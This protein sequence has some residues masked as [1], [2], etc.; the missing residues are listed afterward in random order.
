MA[1]PKKTGLDYYYKDV[2]QMD[3]FRVMDLMEKYGT[4]GYV[5]LDMAMSCVY[6][7]GYYLEMPIKR[8]ASYIYRYVAGSC[9]QNSSDIA[10]MIIYCGE[11]GIFDKELLSQSVITSREIQEHYSNVSAR[12]KADKS[13]YWLLPENTDKPSEEK[14]A[15]AETGINATETGINAAETGIIATETGINATETGINA[16]IIPQSKANK[17]KAN[18]TKQNQIKANQSKSKQSKHTSA[19]EIFCDPDDTGPAD[20]PADGFAWDAAAGNIGEE[21]AA[22]DDAFAD[23]A[24]GEKEEKDDDDGYS[25]IEEAY[26]AAVGRN[27]NDT[28]RADIDTI[29]REG[30]DDRL[31]IYAVKRVASRRPPVKINSFRYFL[32]K[33]RDMLSERDET[34]Y[35]APRPSYRRDDGFI[36][37]DTQYE[38]P[39]AHC[40][41]TEEYLAVLDRE[42]RSQ[43][44]W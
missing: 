1:R 38:N 22:A 37:N 25:E 4:V 41:T 42:F 2:H 27:L 23:D 39:Y 18:E 12:R 43:K 9:T 44:G 8:L 7:N 24:A 35:R 36:H 17:S 33:I 19:D 26:Y 30:A 11:L 20:G 14:H 32:P 3:D 13:K 10:E 29:R 21:Y 5:V 34:T 15:P 16:A 6:R 28:D 40:T 31:I